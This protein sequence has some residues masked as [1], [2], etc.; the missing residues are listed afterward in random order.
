M[1]EPHRDAAL[2]LQGYGAD[3]TRNP[4]ENPVKEPPAETSAAGFAPEAGRHIG[5]LLAIMAA[6]RDPQTGCPWD[7]KQTFATI[8]PYTIEE[9][10][11][12]ADAIV[13]NNL[14][15]LCE[16]LGD[17]LLQVVFHARMAEEAKAFT[18]ADV[19]E[20]ITTK[21]IR[22]HPH[23]FGAQQAASE[24][25]VSRLWAQIKA[26]EKAQKQQNP[27]AP[28]TATKTLA[29][30]PAGLPP[31]RRALALQQEAAKV[32]FAWPD[33]AQVLAKLH[34]ELAEVEEALARSA[35]K[36]NT[37]APAS[38]HA[39]AET[40]FTNNALEEEIGDLLFAVI[41]LARHQGLDPE[42][43]LARTNHKFSQRFEHMEAH[44]HADGLSPAQADL[45]RLETLWHAAKQ[46]IA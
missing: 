33:T 3:T 28:T 19:V 16:E 40:A 15:D 26:Q 20:A 45:E 31:M 44:L 9:T 24:A 35:L 12:V 18:F 23:V 43:A 30:I 22:R 29:A 25:E 10:Y 32:G 46:A 2:A 17:L 42:A 11:E 41:T 21:L 13:R 34:E 27:Q 36:A 4:P 8:L 1:S 6:L 5:Q 39:P 7:I 37:H 38:V 14:P